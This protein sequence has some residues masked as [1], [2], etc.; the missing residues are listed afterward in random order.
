[1][2]YLKFVLSISLSVLLSCSK[3][4][5]RE[6]EERK[7]A[8]A[9]SIELSADIVGSTKAGIT[10]ILYNEKQVDKI[11]YV[12]YDNLGRYEN[13]ISCVGNTSISVL[14]RSGDK[15]IYALVNIDEQKFRAGMSQEE[16]SKVTANFDDIVLND[17]HLPMFGSK[18]V[19]AE[20]GAVVSVVIPVR[21]CVGRLLVSSVK[22]GLT[23]SN[24]G[25]SISLRGIFISNLVTSGCVD[26]TM[27]SEAEWLNQAGRQNDYTGSGEP[28][29]ITTVCF[30]NGNTTNPK[31]STHGS[32]LRHLFFKNIA[33]E[34]EYSTYM[35]IPSYVFYAFPNSTKDDVNGWSAGEFIPRYTRVV[36]YCMID[37]K[38]YYYPASIPNIEANR[39]YTIHVTIRK[40]GS[41]DP[42]K[43]EWE[44]DKDM[45]DVDIDSPIEEGS[46]DMH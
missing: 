31:N 35:S 20:P 13:H 39:S 18:T 2:R 12:I 33:P 21:R 1:M 46:E 22:N 15:T 42:D 14:A 6:M 10:D 43:F 38:G 32:Y 24:A 40:L 16:L 8:D 7:E 30:F 17:C 9:V 36:L 25:K 28:P 37:G 34:E 23:G 41:M 45:V 4:A 44:E 26:G 29:K 19:E 5:V 27:D 11:L 3:I